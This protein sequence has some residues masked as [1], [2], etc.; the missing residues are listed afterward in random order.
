MKRTEL[1]LAVGMLAAVFLVGVSLVATGTL[2]GF[3]SWAW[4]HHHNVFSWYVRPLFILHLAYFSYRRRLSVIVLTLVALA[5][6][7]FWFPAS[8]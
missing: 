8:E 7:M 3:I 5:T 2:D 1:L 6:S 4:E